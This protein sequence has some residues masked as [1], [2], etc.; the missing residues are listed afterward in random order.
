LV[1]K[2]DEGTSKEVGFGPEI[3]GQETVGLLKSIIGCF[4]EV[5]E[6]SGLT[7]W[8]GETVLNSG[9][10]EKLFG[11]GGTND[12]WTSGSG[13]KSYAD[14]TALSSDLHG[15]GMDVSDSVSPIASSDWDQVQ[16]SINKST[17]DGDLDF[18]GNFNSKSDVSILI[19]NGNDSLESSS[20]TS[21]GLLLDWYDL[22]DLIGEFLLCSG[23]EFINDLRFLDGDRVS[24]DL[25]KGLDKVVLN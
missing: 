5:F 15:D 1:G 7:S 16:F 21:L 18:L 24:I 4:D 14:G 8:T 6:G 10:L 19:S 20:L 9:E 22:H 2:S 13:H 12:T 23:K 17:L 25:F 3:R 11:G